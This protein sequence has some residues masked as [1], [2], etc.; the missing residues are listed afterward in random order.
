MKFGPELSFSC[1][2]REILNGEWYVS[3]RGE[4]NTMEEME[5]AITATWTMS[6]AAA[7]G[8]RGQ[9]Q[10]RLRRQ[11]QERNR[12]ELARGYN[13]GRFQKWELDR[14]WS[15]HEFCFDLP[16]AKIYSEIMIYILPECGKLRVSITRPDEMRFDPPLSWSGQGVGKMAF[17]LN[18]LDG[19]F[20]EG[21]YHVDVCALPGAFRRDDVDVVRDGD[22]DRNRILVG[23]RASPT[24][25]LCL[26][27][28][29]TQ[30]RVD[31]N[32]TTGNIDLCRGSRRRSLA[33]R[34]ERDRK[35]GCFIVF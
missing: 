31:R 22:R 26:T 9:Q 15:R 21:R 32:P 13:L 7:H 19:A 34:R 11:V 33:E 4:S 1:P 3:V 24:L 6:G 25:V 30:R 18:P 8:E 20:S 2:A 5:F 27:L 23:S 28:T 16:A 10:G 35:S 29:T 17:R 12:H 14:G